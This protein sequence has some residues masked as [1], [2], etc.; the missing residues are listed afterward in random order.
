MREFNINQYVWVKINEKG[1]QYLADKHKEF[2]LRIGIEDSHPE[3]S[4]KEYY[5][6]QADKDGYTKMQMWCFI[7]DFGGVTSIGMRSYYETTIKFDEKDLI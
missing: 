5:E 2:Y 1:Y 7:D 4:T 6:N 3:L